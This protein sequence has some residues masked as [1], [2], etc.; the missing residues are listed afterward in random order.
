MSFLGDGFLLSVCCGT[1]VQE[2]AVQVDGVGE[3]ELDNDL[4]REV[5][6]LGGDDC[7]EDIDRLGDQIP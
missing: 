1:G 7:V 2:I 6:E 3:D 4:A 5:G